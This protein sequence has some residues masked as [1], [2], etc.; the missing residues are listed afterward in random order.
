MSQ[1]Y[2]RMYLA[3]FN[4]HGFNRTEITDLIS[5]RQF[6]TH[7][8]FQ[9]EYPQHKIHIVSLYRSLYCLRNNTFLIKYKELYD[10]PH[11]AYLYVKT[12]Y[13]NIKS[14]NVFYN[15]LYEAVRTTDIRFIGV[16]KVM[17]I[18]SEKFND[19]YKFKLGMKRTK[20]LQNLI[21]TTFQRLIVDKLPYLREKYSTIF[22]VPL[23]EEVGPHDL[24]SD[25]EM[26]YALKSVSFLERTTSGDEDGNADDDE[27][28]DAY[29]DDEDSDEDD[30]S[31]GSNSDSCDYEARVTVT[32]TRK[33]S[34]SSFSDD[35]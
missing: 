18:I 29:E 17:S 22:T 10:K 7:E 15:N 8:E 9:A 4:R 35:R 24:I 2:I 28:V 23:F 26:D 19:T 27:E 5:A 33:R 32:V 14:P 3:L 11:K 1:E 13:Q 31:Y 25:Q 12:H 30:K 34:R 20:K 16:E 6:I 21:D